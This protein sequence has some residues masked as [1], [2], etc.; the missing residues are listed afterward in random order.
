[1]SIKSELLGKYFMVSTSPREQMLLRITDV[2]T[3]ICEARRVDRITG[4]I[5]SVG[6]AV[7][8]SDVHVPVKIVRIDP[9]RIIILSS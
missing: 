2:Y 4:H 5:I 7:H 6:V 3:N 9:H 1:M 8:L